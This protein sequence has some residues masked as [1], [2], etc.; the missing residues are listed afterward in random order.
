MEGIANNRDALL[1]VF[2]DPEFWKG[3]YDIGT[4]RRTLP[5]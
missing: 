4:V 3:K 1:A 2:G 5:A